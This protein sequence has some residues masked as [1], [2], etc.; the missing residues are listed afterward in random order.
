MARDHDTLALEGA[1]D[2]LGQLIFRFGD[3][4]SAH[5]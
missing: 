3:A 4:M 2:Q 5:V 1:V